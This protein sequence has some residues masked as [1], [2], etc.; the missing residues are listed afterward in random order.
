[1]LRRA[2]FLTKPCRMSGPFKFVMLIHELLFA[3]ISEETL[4]VMGGMAGLRSAHRA[5]PRRM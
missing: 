3:G 4:A 1:M 5:M 2:P